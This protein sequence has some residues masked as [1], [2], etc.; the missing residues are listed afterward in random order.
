[1]KKKLMLVV[2]VGCLLILVNIGI[3]GTSLAYN[4]QYVP[5]RQGESV[6]PVVLVH[7]A[8][9]NGPYSGN[10]DEVISFSGL[11]SEMSTTGGIFYEWD[12]DDGTTGYGKYPTHVYS[13]SGEYYV[14]LSVTNGIGDVYKDIAP[15]YIDRMA[16]HLTPIGGCYYR[17]DVGE[18]ITFDASDSESTGAEIVQYFWNFGDGESAVGEQVTHSY[19]E[20]R[21]HLM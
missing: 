3:F 16:D 13:E 17:G 21:V 8:D 11:G 6:L 18:T 7:H 12:F 4:L 2:L 5:D 20:E 1:M 10:V 14:T 15:V 9:A 19:Y